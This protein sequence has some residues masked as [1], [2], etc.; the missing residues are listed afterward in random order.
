MKTF[1]CGRNEAGGYF[2]NNLNENKMTEKLTLE[3]CYK[4][5]KAR[6]KAD[7]KDF[8]NVFTFTIYSFNSNLSSNQILREENCKLILRDISQLTDEEKIYIN[9]NLF[10]PL[11]KNS[12]SLNAN[13][14]WNSFDELLAVC[15]DKTGLIDYFREKNIMIEKPD[16]FEIGKAVKDV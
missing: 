5:P 15:E 16:W 11:F 10:Y 6:I 1:S 12:V 2:K 9:D 13:A 14:V 8:K 7:T 4:Y 3:D